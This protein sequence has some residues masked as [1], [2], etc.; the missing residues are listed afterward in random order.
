MAKPTD[1]PIQAAFLELILCARILAEAAIRAHP[2]DVCDTARGT[3][4]DA[5]R[6]V[7][8]RLGGE[9]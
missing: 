8:A 7:E 4:I 1:D 5:C 9:D 2:C 6:R 3:V